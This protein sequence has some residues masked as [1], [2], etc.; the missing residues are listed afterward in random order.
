MNFDTTHPSFQDGLVYN[1][2][3][4]KKKTTIYIDTVCMHMDDGSAHIKLMCK[5]VF[6][7]NLDDKVSALQ[8]IVINITQLV[9]VRTQNPSSHESKV[10]VLYQLFLLS[11]LTWRCHPQRM[12]CCNH[13]RHQMCNI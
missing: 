4:E 8:T 1:I 11:A 6:A 2:L 9:E 7:D 5:R 12:V 3:K 13:I 10:E